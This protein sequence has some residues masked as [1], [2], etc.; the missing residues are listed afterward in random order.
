MAEL[1]SKRLRR[2]KEAAAQEEAQRLKLL[3][4]MREVDYEFDEEDFDMGEFSVAVQK[5]I[6]KCVSLRI[7]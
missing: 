7:A 6:D 2:E 3:K 1:E 4:A 5:L